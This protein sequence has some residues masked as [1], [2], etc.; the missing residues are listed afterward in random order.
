MTIHDDMHEFY[1]YSM[2]A[3]AMFTQNEAGQ[4][5]I[6][7]NITRLMRKFADEDKQKEVKRKKILK[8]LEEEIFKDYASSAFVDV[9]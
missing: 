5:M 7:W 1:Y 4:T 9:C 3:H 8:D 2:H 6:E